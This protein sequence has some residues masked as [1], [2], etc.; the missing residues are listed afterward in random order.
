MSPAPKKKTPN[1]ATEFERE[2]LRFFLTRDDLAS[3]LA[4][5]NPSLA[6]LPLLGEMKLIQADTQLAPWVERNF[7]SLEAVRD[8]AANIHF[9]GSE[10]ADV[11]EFRLNNQLNHL[12]PLLIQS[13]RLIL[14]HMRTAPRRGLQSAWFDIAPRIK[15][16][17][18]SPEVMERFADALRPKLK[19]GKRLSF[20]D[21]ENP[22][23][24]ERP[25][26]L[27]AIDYEVEDGLT[28]DE[29]F[30]VWPDSATAEIEGRF[31]L[32]L[33][34]AL[35]AAVA[36]AIEAGVESN[37]GYGL[38]DT[39]VPS[40][41]KHGQNA[42]RSGFFAIV[43]VIAEL[44]TRLVRKD[45]TLA[46][47][48]VRLWQES[49]FRLVRRLALFAAADPAVPAAL[50]ADVLISLPQGELFLPNSS[51]DVFRLIRARWKDFA[52]DKQEI[53]ERR[54]AEGPPADWFRDGSEKER[55][56]DRSRFDLLGDMQRS[57]IQLGAH[58]QCVLDEVH[59]RWPNW[60]LRP[61]EQAG[62][63]IW[64]EGASAIVG[65][66]AKLG[67]VEDEQLIPA[68]KKAADEADFMEGDS[69]QALCQTDPLRALRGLEAQAKLGHWP[70]WAWNPFLWATQKI[71][72]AKP[73]AQI[74]QLLLLCPKE[75]F[76]K[77]AAPASW[78]LDEK[79]KALD[80][81]LLWPLWDRIEETVPRDEEEAD[82]A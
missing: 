16:G 81:A 6:W 69:W 20:Y 77:I 24:P 8:V 47:P 34:N 60:Q 76:S 73:L 23:A 19:I 11:L 21:E 65:D 10:T 78:W 2:Q 28:E 33:T 62:F 51:V 18:L 39:D 41:A 55:M 30:S 64:S 74:A 57:G 80:D 48:L 36:E 59:A 79:S 46:I 35:S 7:T 63:H 37:R 56:I 9:F 68:A 71:D 66:P 82:D 29:V 50:A 43:R 49:A 42:Y 67:D 70:A 1:D 25:S 5:I 72:V 3:T 22:K 75:D 38:S 52:P 53:I 58:A 12:S 15:R 31:L 32:A 61:A 45:A 4:E 13:W 54:I 14:R 26:D 40:V 17:E 44:W 27:M